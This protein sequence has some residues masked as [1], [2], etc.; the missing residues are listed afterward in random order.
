MLAHECKVTSELYRSIHTILPQIM[1]W[2]FTS[3]LEKEKAYDEVENNPAF[4]FVIMLFPLPL[5]ETGRLHETG[6][7]LRQ[8][9]IMICRMY[10][11]INSFLCCGMR[12]FY[13]RIS[14]SLLSKLLST[15]KFQKS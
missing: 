15:N 11:D 6:P 8:Y 5:N 10:Y 4:I 13:I 3:F 1:A 12:S 9:S 7:S 14:T 2:A